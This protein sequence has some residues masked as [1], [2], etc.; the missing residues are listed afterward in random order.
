[1]IVAAPF[2]VCV[3]IYQQRRAQYQMPMNVVRL[4]KVFGLPVITNNR[5]HN[6]RCMLA[7]SASPSLT[8]VYALCARANG[9]PLFV[10]V[11]HFDFQ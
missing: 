3:R 4:V 5:S 8:Y 9:V 7:E 11:G 10:A 6:N 1:M 2:P